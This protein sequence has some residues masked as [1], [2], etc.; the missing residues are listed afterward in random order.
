MGS[1]DVASKLNK[2]AIGQARMVESISHNLTKFPLAVGGLGLFGVVVFGSSFPLLCVAA[3]GMVVGV[4][5]WVVNYFI[6]GD[7]LSMQYIRAIQSQ[8]REANENKKRAVKP[9]LEAC[10]DVAGAEEFVDRALLQFDHVEG[11]FDSLMTVLERKLSVSE[12]T[13]GVFAG[14]AEQVANG[15]LDNFGMIVT[16]LEGVRSIDLEHLTG[17]LAELKKI[18]KPD[19]LDIKEIKTLTDRDE[20]YRDVMRKV[21]ELLVQNEE[22]ITALELSTR[23]IGEMNTQERFSA[24]AANEAAEELRKV[25]QRAQIYNRAS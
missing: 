21:D 11:S 17:R 1:A 13:F 7:E 9:Q 8:I 20:I 15:V 2:K 19:D 22:A 14:P 4:S 24:V 10:R 5:S 18:R 3:G 23:Q 6:R 25:A 16:R 12:L